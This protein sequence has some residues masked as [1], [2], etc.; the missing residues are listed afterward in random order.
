MGLF[1]KK[2]YTCSQ[3][4]KEYEAR[5][6]LGE[7]L[8]SNC[9][10][11]EKEAKKA[12]SGYV[13]YGRIIGRNYSG[14][15]LEAIAKHRD[16]ILEKYR[17]MDTITKKELEEAGDN[18]K[19]LSENEAIDIYKKALNA[20]V[21]TTL[22]A[23]STSNFY[24]LTT[25][26]DVVVDT[27]DVFAVGYTSDLK[28]SNAYKE[29]ILCAVFTND[30]YVPVFP[31]GY[32]ASIGLLSF[33]LK[34]KEGRQGVEFIYG[35]ECPNLAYPV[36]DLKKLKKMIKQDGTKGNIDV[37]S[38]LDY[39]SDARSG[40]GMFNTKD[41]SLHI[42]DASW[43]KLATYGYIPYEEVSRLLGFDKMFA[44][45]FWK[46]IATKAEL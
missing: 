20:S 5:I 38:M 45:S 3:C 26:N 39:I 19:K 10:Q 18:Y 2:T 44:K 33:S 29:N 9:Q 16:G 25:F 21:N 14:D 27:K 8:C 7:S 40:S 28:T 6:N 12:V 46:D 35:S 4:G 1:S 22:G 43:N 24:Y 17:N 13:E 31:V 37:S 41:M 30:P 42:R 11:K 34:S 36:T 23:L 32:S 15:E